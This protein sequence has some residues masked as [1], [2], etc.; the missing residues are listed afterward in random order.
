LAGRRHIVVE[1]NRPVRLTFAGFERYEDLAGR[2]EHEA[3]SLCLEMHFNYRH[4]KDFAEVY[5]EAYSLLTAAQYLHGKAHQGDHE[6]IR[7]RITDVD[8]LFHHLQEDMRGWTRS[9][10][11]QIGAGSLPY[12]LASVEAVLHHLCYDV[13]VEPHDHAEAAPAPDHA[14]ELVPPPPSFP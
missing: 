10:T 11:R 2:L 12:K 7:N 13:G 5:R 6:T 4:N 3:N 1:P 14:G 8:R 9:A